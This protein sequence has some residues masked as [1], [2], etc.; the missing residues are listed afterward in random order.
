MGVAVVAV[1]YTHKLNGDSIRAF[2][3]AF[4][5]VMVYRF[6]IDLTMVETPF[7]WYQFEHSI[8]CN[9]SDIT[10]ANLLAEYRTRM[11]DICQSAG[12]TSCLYMPSEGGTELVWDRAQGGATFEQLMEFVHKR[13]F[14][15]GPHD[16]KERNR[17][18]R[19]LVLN[20]SEYMMEHM[21]FTQRDDFF[22]DVVVDDFSDMR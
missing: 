5:D 17:V 13:K 11:R 22:L 12:C 21:L 9:D 14:L 15:L 20:L 19:S 1:A 6:A 4:P 2:A 10:S 8:W 7:R 18:R 16:K 3:K